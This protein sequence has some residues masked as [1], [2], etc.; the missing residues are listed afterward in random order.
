MPS[1]DGSWERSLQD[2]SLRCG[3]E[4]SVSGT[5]GD[6]ATASLWVVAVL[7]KSFHLTMYAE[8]I[9]FLYSTNTFSVEPNY[10]PPFSNMNH[11]FPSHC[12]ASIRS[13]ELLY[14]VATYRDLPVLDRFTSTISHIPSIFP[15]LR[16]FHIAISSWWM[17]CALEHWENFTADHT[18]LVKSEL[19]GTLDGLVRQFDGRLRE[20]EVTVDPNYYEIVRL[21]EDESGIERPIETPV[22]HWSQK[23]SA[24]KYWRPVNEESDIRKSQLG[25]WIIMAC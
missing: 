3:D 24:K 18:E 23:L 10:F 1:V 13:L 15:R 16:T 25:Y 19:L 8:S 2:S 11:L 20:C 4:L 12:L 14:P 7:S 6:G 22:L 5:D 17:L 21:L 9:H